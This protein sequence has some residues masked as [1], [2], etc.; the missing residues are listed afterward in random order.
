[1]L[2][3]FVRP[4]ASATSAKH[5]PA[6]PSILVLLVLLSS[7]V[8][9]ESVAQEWTRYRGP[10][11]D[12]NSETQFPSKWNNDAYAWSV[13]LPGIGHSSPVVWGEKLFV[14]SA[15]PERGTQFILCLDTDSGKTLWKKQFESTSYHIHPRNSFASSSP[16][17]DEKA[18]YFAWATPDKIRLYALSH[19]GDP[20]WSR[21]DLGPYASSHGFGSSP[22]IAENLLILP[23]LQKP[24]DRGVET[25]SVLAF[26][27]NTGEEVWATPRT[28]GK[29]SY[30]VPC[31]HQGND[32]KPELL[33]CSTTHGMFGLDLATGAEKWAV[34]DAFKMRTVSSPLVVGNM[35][36]GSTGSGGGGNYVTAIDLETHSVAYTVNRQA[37]YVPTPVAHEGMLFMWYDKGV[38]TCIDAKTGDSHWSKRIGGNYSG[39]PIVSGGKVYCIAEDGTAVVLAASKEYKLLGK[40][41][42]GE[43]SRSTPSVANGKMFL[44]TNSKLFCLAAQ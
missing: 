30:S 43:D 36:F 20:L 23:N 18:V 44:R 1:M 27:K 34:R 37:P 29:A 2:S 11:G 14:Q 38:V 28:S 33:L 32:G 4:C 35:V 21:Q 12:G 24:S 25:S 42:L 7:L 8:G 40:T 26:N 9:S 31:L 15:D 6:S 5:G 13:D 3:I 16:V 19:D 10:N 41:P 17:V 39:S 22:I